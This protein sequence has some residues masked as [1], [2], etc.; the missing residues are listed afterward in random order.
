MTS[1]LQDWVMN[2]PLRFQGTILTAIRGC[3]M[4]PKDHI[5]K[6]LARA[7]RCEIMNTP[8]TGGGKVTKESVKPSTFIE[9]FEHEDLL[10]IMNEF[11]RD[12]DPYPLHYVLHVAHASEVIGY[13]L[14]DSGED[15]E[16]AS[17][18]THLYKLIC[19]KFHMYPESFEQLKLRL[20]AK[21]EDFG[22]DQASTE[23]S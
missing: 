3:D 14:H 1:V 9:Y 12:L 2:L 10:E 5:A 19:R 20:N 15:C 4:V 11:C 22:K 13:C 21:E 18:W 23:T 16:R 6:K 7:I 8:C 17:L